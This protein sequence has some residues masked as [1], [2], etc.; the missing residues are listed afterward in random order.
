MRHAYPQHQP[1]EQFQTLATCF[2][3]LGA[4]G[5]HYYCD[6]AEVLEVVEASKHQLDR[7]FGMGN[8]HAAALIRTL[9]NALK[10]FH[11]KVPCRT[12]LHMA[13]LMREAAV[14][15]TA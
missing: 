10:S 14:G 12:V 7:R 6:K 4:A 3:N 8:R 5:E 11:G 9:A 13:A 1:S 2:Q 15:R